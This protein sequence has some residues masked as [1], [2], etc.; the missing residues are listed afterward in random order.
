MQFIETALA[1]AITM[2]VLSMVV[3]TFVELIHRVFSMREAGLRYVMGQIFDQV[4]EKQIRKYKE[5]TPNFLESLDIDKIRESFVERMCANRVPM[6][7]TPKTT[8]SINTKD[9]IEKKAAAPKSNGSSTSP[10]LGVWNGRDLASMTP[11]QFMERLATID[12]GAVVA[13]A[14]AAANDKVKTAADVTDAVL[15]DV[16]Q[17]FEAFGKEASSYF[18]GRARLMSVIVAMVFAVIAHVDAVELVG[19]FLRDPNVRANVIK[20]VDAVMEQQKK[21]EEAVN[22]AE[23]VKQKA[24]ADAETAK[25]DTPPVAATPSPAVVAPPAQAAAPPPTAATPA[26][27]GG[28]T[29]VKTDQEKLEAARKE[30]DQLKT[31]LQKAIANTKTTLGQLNDYGVPIGWKS[32][33]I[34]TLWPNKELSICVDKTTGIESPLPPDGCK[35]TEYRKQ[36]GL[37]ASIKLLASLLLGGFLIGLGAPFWRDAIMG[38]TNIRNVASSVIGTNTQAKVAGA[39]ADAAAARAQPV[40]PVGAFRAARPENP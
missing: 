23:A 10:Y 36:T 37:W 9:A 12:L 13:E 30:V 17:K 35:S 2:L 39:A 3:S 7:A 22:K 25:Q 1:F 21:S 31:D 19:A 33:E 34:D 16:A 28:A 18:E 11:S 38:L 4:L 5:K 8:P 26:T 6:S 27:A 32:A 20:Q 14:N 40:T 24:K 29:P 15:K